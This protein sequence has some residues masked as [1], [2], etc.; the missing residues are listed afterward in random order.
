MSGCGVGGLVGSEC[1][2]ISYHWFCFV[3]WCC[4]VWCDV[5]CGVQHTIRDC[6]KSV[7]DRTQRHILSTLRSTHDAVGAFCRL[8]S[9]EP[10]AVTTASASASSGKE[11]SSDESSGALSSA[12]AGA[13]AAESDGNSKRLERERELDRRRRRRRRVLPSALGSS[14]V[15]ASAYAVATAVREHCERSLQLLSPLLH[16][17]EY[18]PDTLGFAFMDLAHS[19]LHQVCLSA[20]GIFFL[21]FFLMFCS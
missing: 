1:D 20:H 13:G 6:E 15:G 21:S 3:M 11:D 2:L 7:F 9:A 14:G 18:L 10:Y 17:A 4:V 19:H 5:M 16:T 8:L 12:G